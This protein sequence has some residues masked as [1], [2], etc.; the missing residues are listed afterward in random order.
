MHFVSNFYRECGN[1]EHANDLQDCCLAFTTRHFTKLYNILY[2]LTNDGGKEFLRRNMK[3]RPKWAR[4]YDYGG[5]RYG[6]MTSN[7]AE[8][9]NTVL[10]GVCQLLVTWQATCTNASIVSWEVSVNCPWQKYRNILMSAFFCMVLHHN[11]I[12]ISLSSNRIFVFYQALLCL[13]M[14]DLKIIRQWWN[15]NKYYHFMVF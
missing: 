3:E 6:D 1:K 8:C 5:M 11:F 13:S 7:M 12:K 2:G 10:R 15:I 4:A 14:Q 9:F